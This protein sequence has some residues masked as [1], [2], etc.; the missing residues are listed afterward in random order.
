MQLCV[1]NCGSGGFCSGHLHEVCLVAIWVNSHAYSFFNVFSCLLTQLFSHHNFT[2]TTAYKNSLFTCGFDNLSK[3]TCLIFKQLKLSPTTLLA[4]FMCNT[5]KHLKCIFSIVYIQC[6]VVLQSLSL[7][8]FCL[9][10][11]YCI[12]LCIIISVGPSKLCP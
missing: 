8:D 5:V 4:M 2:S 1:G 10:A 12:A 11:F 6:R 3:E 9:Y 7:R